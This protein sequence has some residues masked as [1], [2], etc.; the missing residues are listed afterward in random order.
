MKKLNGSINPSDLANKIDEIV[1]A[2]NN[3]PAG[4]LTEDQVRSIASVEA[5]K[6]IDNALKPNV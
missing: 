4:G 3:S 6:A 2:L 5:V 1:E